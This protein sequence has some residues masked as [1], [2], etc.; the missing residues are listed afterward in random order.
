ME[1]TVFDFSHIRGSDSVEF[2][3]LFKVNSALQSAVVTQPSFQWTSLLLYKRS[4]DSMK[5][6]SSS[7]R[8]TQISFI[9]E[10]DPVL[11]Q[12]LFSFTF[13][14]YW[15]FRKITKIVFLIVQTILY[16]YCS[17]MQ[18]TDQV[19]TSKQRK[20]SG[21]LTI[22]L[23]YILVDEWF[24]TYGDWW[25]TRYNSYQLWLCYKTSVY[26]MISSVKVDLLIDM[27]LRLVGEKGNTSTFSKKS[28]I[29]TK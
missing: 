28:N 22:C 18:K 26:Y 3:L 17:Y 23:R 9:L 4:C 13:I 27:W 1:S 21:V 15:M 2:D 14:I 12:N 10:L 20:M 16:V 8:V 11:S 5:D 19:A 25:G 29:I 24:L 7:R 6:Y